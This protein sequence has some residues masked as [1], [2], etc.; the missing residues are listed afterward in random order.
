MPITS[1]DCRAVALV[2][3]KETVRLGIVRHPVL[4]IEEAQ[5]SAFKDLQL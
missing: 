5:H 1:S 4:P 3:A 2:R